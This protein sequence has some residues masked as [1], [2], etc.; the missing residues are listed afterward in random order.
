MKDASTKSEFA[1]GQ[2]LF[3]LRGTIHATLSDK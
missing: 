3:F 2:L 1:P